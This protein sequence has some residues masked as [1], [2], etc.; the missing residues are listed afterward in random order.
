MEHILEGATERV[1][2]PTMEIDDVG[3]LS[4]DPERDPTVH[5]YFFISK[6]KFI[7]AFI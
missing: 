4:Y 1:R 3:P 5:Y 2:N 6:T 7:I